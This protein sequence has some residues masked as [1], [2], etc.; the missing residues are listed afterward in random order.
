MAGIIQLMHHGVAGQ[1]GMVGLD[2]QLEVVHQAVGPEEIDAGRGVAVV[3]VLGRLLRFR[4]DQELAREADLLGVVDRQVHE[5]GHVV[6]FPLHVGV[7][8]ILVSLASAPEHIVH[9]AQ[10][11]GDLE[12]L[13]HLCGGEGKRVGVAAGRGAV[14]V[15]RIAEQVGRAP[16]QLDAGPLLLFLHHLHHG[17]QVL[18]GLRQVLPFRG[19]VAI[20]K[21]VVRRTE[22]VDELERGP[23]ATDR[24]GQRIAAVVPRPNHGRGAER[25]GARPAERVPIDDAKAEVLLHRLAFHDFVLVVPTEGK[26]VLRVR[27]FVTNLRNLG[28]C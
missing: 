27:T 23:N 12:A 19:H 20:M 10:F 11:L 17:V 2:V 21:G 24:V 18:V 14:H 5:P 9:A 4:L 6:Q 1:G 8:K 7:E 15:A 25:I 3:L 28:K 16:E 13:L 22:F 26:R